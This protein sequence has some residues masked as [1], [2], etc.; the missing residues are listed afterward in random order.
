MDKTLCEHEY[1]KYRPNWESGP[2]LVCASCGI[3]GPVAERYPTL[4]EIYREKVV[5][6]LIP[7]LITPIRKVGRK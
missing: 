5:D 2:I 1:G 6:D 4:L 3:G 7:V